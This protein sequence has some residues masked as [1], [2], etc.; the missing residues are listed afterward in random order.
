MRWHNCSKTQCLPVKMLNRIR[1]QGNAN[2]NHNAIVLYHYQSIG[3]N[4]G[5]QKHCPYSMQVKNDT[6]TSLENILA[7][8]YKGEYLHTS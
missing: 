7:P 8:P 1:N 5:G 6:S 4:V 2:S 3:Q